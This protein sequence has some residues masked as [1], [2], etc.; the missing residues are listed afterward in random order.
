MVRP[1]DLSRRDFLR[2][3][4]AAGVMASVV[5]RVKIISQDSA[6]FRKLATFSR[7]PSNA[8]VER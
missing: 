2:T 8:A 5:P 1:A 3:A 6:A 4:A 7:A